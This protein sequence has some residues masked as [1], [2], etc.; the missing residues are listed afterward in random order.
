LAE[1]ED[2]PLTEE[3]HGL[4]A[5]MGFESGLTDMEI[6]VYPFFSF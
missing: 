4:Q 2:E 6:K 3:N 5:D 1:D